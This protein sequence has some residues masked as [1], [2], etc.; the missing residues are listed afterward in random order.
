MYQAVVWS[1]H[2]LRIVTGSRASTLA[3]WRFISGI[4]GTNVDLEQEVIYEPTSNTNTGPWGARL[5]HGKC[6]ARGSGAAGDQGRASSRAR[7]AAGGC[8]GNRLQSADR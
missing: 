7:L 3:Y 4:R 8:G 5:P 1:F 2:P 6:P